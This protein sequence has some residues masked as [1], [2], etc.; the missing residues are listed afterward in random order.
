MR[1]KK[2]KPTV[3]LMYNRLA[4]FILNEIEL[5][6]NMTILEGGC[7]R[8]QLT[9]PL[10]NLIEK[11][12]HNYQYFA[13]D[14]S[15]GPYEHALDSLREKIAIK[16]WDTRIEV[17]EGDVTAING[18]TDEFFSLILSNE[19]FC[20]LGRMGL[21]KALSEF[22]RILKSNGQMCHSELIPFPANYPQ[23]LFI[24]ADSYSI[25]TV[26]SEYEWF[27]P[28]ADEVIALMYKTGFREFKVKYFET[29]I[30]LAFN[31][32]LEELKG[33][34]IDEGFIHTY[35]NELK[36]HGIEYPL[37]HVIYCRK[38]RVKSNNM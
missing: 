33:W 9:I 11:K 22:Y 32:A 8:G 37:S 21:N 12:I 16:E 7:G 14:L 2:L 3:E 27:S 1:P 29:N 4:E 20:D 38:P 31:D 25:E 5:T 26:T 13:V 36:E 23:E 6:E 24:K 17:L 28:C 10:I 30:K 34:H 35:E 18:V 15:S 19:L